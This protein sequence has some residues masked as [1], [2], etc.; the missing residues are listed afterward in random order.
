MVGF[1]EAG[2][3]NINNFDWGRRSLVFMFKIVGL[4][5][6]GGPC[7]CVVC[8]ANWLILMLKEEGEDRYK[9]K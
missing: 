6:V 8:S 5:G 3:K 7:T 2:I 9:I 4:R 1:T